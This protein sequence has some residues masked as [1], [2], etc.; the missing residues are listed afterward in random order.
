M[1]YTN[2]G[3][4]LYV[5]HM[6]SGDRVAT[7]QEITAH[8]MSGAL[9]YFTDITTE[10]IESK[11]QAY[12]QANGL[13]FKDIDAFTK[14]A[15]NTQSIHNVIANRFVVY[16]DKVWAAVRTYQSTATTIPTDIEFK[17]ILDGVIF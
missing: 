13:A 17:A 3:I 1:Y 12:N 16:A 9:T 14:Y 6:Q 15:I 5:G 2:D 4:K 11:V 10:Y 8:E 7:L